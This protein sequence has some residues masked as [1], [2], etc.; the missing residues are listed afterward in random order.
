MRDNPTYLGVGVLAQVITQLGTLTTVDEDVVE[1]LFSEDLA[2][3]QSMYIRVND[4][5]AARVD[6]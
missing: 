2:Y 4:R 5:T 3:L 1:E 6:P